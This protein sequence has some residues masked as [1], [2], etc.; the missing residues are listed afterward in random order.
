MAQL[1]PLFSARRFLILHSEF[2]LHHSR[3]RFLIRQM[4]SDLYLIK[5][6]LNVHAT[7]GLNTDII[8]PTHLRGELLNIGKQLPVRL[9][10][11]E[12][13]KENIWH[14]YKFLTVTPLSHGDNLILMIRV[15]LIDTDSGMKLYKTYNLH[16]FHQNL[17]KSLQ[18]K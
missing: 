3:I 12:D 4:R 14:Y 17:G 5:Q 11:P 1:K 2:S 15:P 16:I 9:S 8:D 6:Y 10:L 18:Y 7:G 13:P